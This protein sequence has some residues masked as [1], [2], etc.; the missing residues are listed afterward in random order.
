MNI[1]LDDEKVPLENNSVPQSDSEEKSSQ[2]ALSQENRIPKSVWG[3]NSLPKVHL[4]G[5]S[6]SKAV[7]TTSVAPAVNPAQPKGQDV[8]EAEAQNLKPTTILDSVILSH[9]PSKAVNAE[10]AGP[11]KSLYEIVISDFSDEDSEPL[12]RKKKKKLTYDD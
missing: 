8:P 9:S 2:S 11:K 7:E 12:P 4:E 6:I 10:A 1:E 5:R 3:S